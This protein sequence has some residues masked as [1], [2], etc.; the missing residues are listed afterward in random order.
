MVV[1]EVGPPLNLACAF[2][3]LTA[4]G[5]GAALGIAIGEPVI[6]LEASIFGRELDRADESDGLEPELV[7]ERRGGLVN[8]G[9][10]ARIVLESEANV[11]EAADAT[12]IGDRGPTEDGE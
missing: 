7:E 6:V 4:G 5:Y 8:E 11:L 9:V 10:C 3:R 12:A 2:G 1:G